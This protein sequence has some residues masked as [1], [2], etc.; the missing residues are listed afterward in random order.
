MIWHI[1]MFIYSFVESFN[2][3]GRKG[4]LILGA[5]AGIIALIVLVMNSC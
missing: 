1:K 3:Y 5:I 2:A 4:M